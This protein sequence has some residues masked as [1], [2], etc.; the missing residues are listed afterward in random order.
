MPTVLTIAG[1]D[2]SGGAGIQAD[3][4]VFYALKARGVSAISAVTAQNEGRF[5]SVN[6]L[7]STLLREQLRAVVAPHRPDA[8]KIGMLGTEENVLA[9]YRFLEGEPMNN[10]VLDPVFRASTGMILLEPKGIAIL[11]QFLIP[12]VTVVTPNLEEA[13]VLTGIKLGNVDQMKEATLS[14]HET[15]RGVKAVVIKGGHLEGEAT[16]VLYDGRGWHLYASSARFAKRV[17]GTG[18]VY[19]A[20]LAASLAHGKTIPDAC[21]LAKEYATEWIRKRQ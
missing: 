17:H 2:P 19:S 16:D 15:C 3:L 10:V 14:L 7:P 6:P 1:S 4:Q 5:F 13:E 20:A 12:M 11:K 21:R 9:V 8:T 18:C